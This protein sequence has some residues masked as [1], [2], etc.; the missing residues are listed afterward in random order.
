MRKL[1]LVLAVLILLA[2]I[3]VLYPNYVEKPIKDGTGPLAVYISA[4]YAAPEYHSPLDYWQTHHM[5]MVNR[6]D[7]ERADCLYCHIPEYSCNNC[8][9]YVGAQRIEK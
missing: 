5:D 7:L 1:I 3:A 6:G 2:T 9:T 4:E 8:H